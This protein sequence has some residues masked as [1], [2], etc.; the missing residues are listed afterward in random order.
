MRIRL[1]TTLCEHQLF[2]A[3]LVAHLYHERWSM[4]AVS[5]R[6]RPTRCL[7]N[8]PT[9][10]RSQ[11]PRTTVQELYGML[12]AHLAIRTLMYEAASPRKH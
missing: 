4:K 6:S 10:L 9:H 7:P 3:A 5:T 12:L 11:L 2:P 8:R 1:L